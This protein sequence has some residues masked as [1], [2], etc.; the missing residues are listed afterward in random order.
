MKCLRGF[1]TF[2]VIEKD[3]NVLKAGCGDGYTCKCTKIELDT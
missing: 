1:P 3:E 2:G